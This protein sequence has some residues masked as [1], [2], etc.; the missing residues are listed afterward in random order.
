MDP[1][2]K[3]YS[4]LGN[5]HPRV[6]L[7]SITPGTAIDNACAPEADEDSEVRK[8][9]A[10]LSCCRHDGTAVSPT[11][12]FR[13]HPTLGSCGSRRSSSARQTVLLDPRRVLETIVPASSRAAYRA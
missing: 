2:V 4:A 5:W 13:F 10:F 1:H 8:A 6:G 11:R 12:R 3:G 7:P 9:R